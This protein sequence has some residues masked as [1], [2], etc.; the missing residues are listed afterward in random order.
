MPSVSSMSCARPRRAFHCLSRSVLAA[1]IVLVA[2]LLALCGCSSDDGHRD[3]ARIRLLN[4]SPG[5]EALDLSVSKNG[6]DN[7][8]VKFQAVGYEGL[9]DYSEVD[10]TAYDIKVK[11]S[12]VVGTLTTFVDEKQADNTHLTYV[13][14]GALGNFGMLKLSDDQGAADSGKT[15]LKVLNA[16]TAGNLNVYLTDASV[17]LDDA[18]PQF[19][20]VA[21]RTSSTVVNLDSGT[22]RLRV[23]LVGDNTDVRLDIPNLVLQSKQVASLILTETQGGVLVNGLLLPQGGQLAKNHNTKAR[24]RGAIGIASGSSVSAAIAG[25]TVLTGAGVGVISNKYLQVDAGAA[26]VTLKVDGVVI[27]RDTETLV[28]GADYTML[29]WS[30]AAGPQMSLI[31][32]DNRIS[33]SAKARLRFLNGLSA[34]GQPTTMAVNLSPIFEGV[35]VGQASDYEEFDAGADYQIDVADTGTNTNLLT[36]TELTLEGSGVYTLFVSGNSTVAGTLRKDH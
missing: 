24:V 1:P 13:A 11:R 36:K 27:P 8:I 17:D 15:K 12:G 14:F 28:P 9:S 29:F 7:D 34:L 19:A 30:N 6:E 3:Y 18:T 33:T 16:T 32:D 4:V 31:S 23:V 5:Y 22:Y 26:A 35:P 21:S 10:S 20:S 2:A 25:T